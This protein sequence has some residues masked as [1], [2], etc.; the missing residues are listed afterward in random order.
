MV[1]Y[2]IVPASLD[3][4]SLCVPWVFSRFVYE[5]GLFSV[6]SSTRPNFFFINHHRHHHHHH[7][8]HHH[9]RRRRRRRRCRCRYHGRHPNIVIEA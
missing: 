6:C 1:F 9:R 5:K 8:H 3:F 2:K 7:H 4:V